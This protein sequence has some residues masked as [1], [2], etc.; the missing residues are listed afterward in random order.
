MSQIRF[1]GLG[2]LGENGKNMFVCEVDERIFVLDAGLKYPSVDLFGIDTI[3]PDISYLIKNKNKVQGIFISHG[4]EDHIGALVELLK[5]LN[6][7]VFGTHFTISILED[8][9]I[10]NGLKV[11][12]YRLYRINEQKKLKFGDVVVEFYNVNHSIPETVHVVIKTTD[13]CIIYAPDFCF[14]VNA[15]KKYRTSFNRINDVSKYG[16]LALCCESLGT[17][18]VDRVQNNI[19]SDHIINEALQKEQRVIFSLFSTDLERIQRVVNMSVANNR[20]VAIIGRRAQK[21]VNTAISSGYLELPEEKLI[22]LKYIDDNHNNNDKDLVIIVTGIRHE[23]FYMLQRM[24]RGQDRLVEIN[25]QDQIIM[26]TPPVP[27]TERMAARTLDILLK[28]GAEVIN[29]KKNQ[30]RSSHANAEDLKML[31]SMLNPKYIVPIIGE[32]RHQYQHKNI[33]ISSGYTEEKIIILDNG[34][35]ALFSD[36]IYKGIKEKVEVGDVLVDGSIIG[37]INEV[38][39]KDREMLSQEGVVVVATTIDTRY[40]NIIAGPEIVIKGVV[41][42]EDMKEATEKVK[43]VT[44]NSLQQY[45]NKRYIDWNEAKVLLRDKIYN[46]INRMTKKNPIIIL[47]I[48]DINRQ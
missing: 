31:Y 21:I 48:I 12:D 7:G 1:F 8:M 28:S 47:S 44:F 38:V 27:G 35:V 42:T 19:A 4:H 37:D 10:E 11:S 43:E 41:L 2:G 34:D 14:D 39:L 20:R 3:I 16:V 40:R 24:C 9:I 46:I 36:G 26:M 23:P 22:N 33:A 45:M 5:K 6:V 17:S 13:G 25:G 30:M 29:I 18:N 32:Y 15:D